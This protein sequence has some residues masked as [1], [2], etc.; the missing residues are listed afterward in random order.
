[1]GFLFN[2]ILLWN[3]KNLII[4]YNIKWHYEQVDAEAEAKAELIDADVLVQL[5]EPDV[6]PELIDEDAQPEA[7]EPLALV[8]VDVSIDVVVVTDVVVEL[9]ADVDKEE[10]ILI[11]SSVGKK[12]T[13]PMIWAPV[14]L[15]AVNQ[16]GV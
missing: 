13:F 12:E 7:E 6:E 2:L 10:E 15:D 8:S 5:E 4:Y 9:D 14:N 1:M 3:E 16:N 11:L